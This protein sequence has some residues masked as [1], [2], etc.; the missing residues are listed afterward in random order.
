MFHLHPIA[1][2]SIVLAFVQIAPGVAL[3]MAGPE[4]WRYDPGDDVMSVS[5]K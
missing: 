2:V 3:H 5:R 4:T 1:H